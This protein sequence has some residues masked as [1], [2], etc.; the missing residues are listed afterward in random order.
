MEKT[1]NQV[2]REVTEEYLKTL[3]VSKSP[4]V[5]EAEILDAMKYEYELHNSV[6]DKGQK[7]RYSDSM[8]PVQIAMILLAK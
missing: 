3:D 6:A 8:A 4:A 7:W 2:L 1:K 5:I